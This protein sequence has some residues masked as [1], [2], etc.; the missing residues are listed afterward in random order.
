[1]KS[2]LRFA[3]AAFVAL[4]VV[5]QA[6]AHFVFIHVVRGAN[7]RVEVHFSEGAW[8]FSANGQF[9][10]FLTKLEA[11]VA[12]GE[13][14]KFEATP[15][16]YVA[17][18]PDGASSVGGHMTFG[19]T[20]RG[21]VF[22]LE[23]DARGVSNLAA[24]ANPVGLV[25]EVIAKQ[26]EDGRLGLTVLFHGKP[27]PGAEIVVPIAG[28]AQTETLETDANG[29]VVI[30]RPET[31]L[32]SIRARVLETRSGE[33]DGKVFEEVRHYTTL[34]VH[35]NGESIPSGS[36]GVAWG[37]LNDVGHTTATSIR[38][39][40]EH[41][42]RLS[43]TLDGARTNAG[44]R[45]ARGGYE[46]DW[47]GPRTLQ[48]TPIDGDLQLMFRAFD[49]RVLGDEAVTFAG[50][51]HAS[52]GRTVQ[53]GDRMRI[54]IL[55]RQIL[56]I[57]ENLGETTRRTEF[58]SFGYTHNDRFLPETF[59]VTTFNSGS[60]EIV[61]V[62]LCERSYTETNSVYLPTRQKSRRLLPGGRVS[63]RDIRVLDAA[64]EGAGRRG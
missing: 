9:I 18:L 44:I 28:S 59:V 54:E 23:Y 30:D 38:S 61:S 58:R 55:D 48:V 52:V 5:A 41:N 21:G 40:G 26:T 10:S 8:D 60:G 11:S 12:G 19:V 53:V 34:T 47:E 37:L 15:Y 1:M 31:P 49:P 29:M 50:L 14:L 33:L 64:A 62:D 32:F 39:L 43:M 6:S 25:S 36:D 7:P 51:D 57:V 17:D 45:F 56:S 16:G 63:E 24:A 27:S 35:Q 20:D 3:V 42:A 22:L 46:V 13:S 4:F 2:L